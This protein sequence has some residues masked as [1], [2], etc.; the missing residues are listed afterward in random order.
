MQYNLLKL[1]L[2]LA[3]LS[4][5]AAMEQSD[6]E[7]AVMPPVVEEPLSEEELWI[8]ETIDGMT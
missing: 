4:S 6:I 2:M 5:G 8:Q 1:L 7:Y 3:M